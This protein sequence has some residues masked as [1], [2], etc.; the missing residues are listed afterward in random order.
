MIYL[1]N[2]IFSVLSGFMIDL[3]IRSSGK[4]YK[5]KNKVIFILLFLTWVFILGFQN[6]VGTDYQS[7]IDIY[8]NK[9]ETDKIYL[10]KKE[11]IFIYLIKFL[12][13]LIILRLFF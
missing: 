12:R 3:V 4:A 11:Y 13:F 7:Y 6:D 9:F 1:I 10:S 8:L 2:L 5:I